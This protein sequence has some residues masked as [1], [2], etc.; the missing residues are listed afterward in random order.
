MLLLLYNRERQD[1]PT[2]NSISLLSTVAGRLEAALRDEYL[3]PMLID[4]DKRRAVNISKEVDHEHHSLMI[5]QVDVGTHPLVA[6]RLGVHPEVELPAIRILRGDATYG[7]KI[8][9]PAGEFVTRTGKAVLDEL[10]TPVNLLT[11]RPS[12]LPRPTAAKG[13]FRG[14]QPTSLPPFLVVATLHTL[15]SVCALQLVAH[16]FRKPDESSG[17]PS[18]AFALSSESTV[19]AAACPHAALTAR[20]SEAL[21]APSSVA[22][23]ASPPSLPPLAPP[24]RP[25]GHAAD[26]SVEKV[27]LY[28]SETPISTP[29]EMPHSLVQA[30]SKGFSAGLEA[31]TLHSWVHWAALPKWAS[32]DDDLPVMANSATVAGGS[33][34][35]G[36]ASK[37]PLRSMKPIAASGCFLREGDVGILIELPSSRKVGTSAG[38][39]GLTTKKAALDRLREL[40]SQLISNGF[41]GLTLLH[42][43][44]G[45]AAFHDLVTRLKVATAVGNEIEST[46]T[47]KSAFLIVR[48]AGSRVA[49]AKL[50]RQPADDCADGDEALYRFCVDFLKARHGYSDASGGDA[51]AAARKKLLLAVLGLALFALLAG[52]RL[53]LR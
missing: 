40:S 45:G 18:V 39:P 16:T 31:K 41:H 36:A 27:V 34:R 10:N 4:P 17:W 30:Q 33:A 11:T 29:F 53:L 25:A 49:E 8:R 35:G 42:V 43:E 28:S 50:L 9:A 21:H 47:S 46:E 44:R 52:R 19:D 20:S 1:S 32:L 14:E 22:P 23:S 37:G 48:L 15:E 38:S 6:Y 26:L 24:S 51:L 7:Y 12:L 13:V 3:D 5:A 2:K